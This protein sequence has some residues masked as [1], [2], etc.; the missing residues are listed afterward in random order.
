MSKPLSLLSL[1]NF[2]LHLNFSLLTHYLA[3]ISTTF[4]STILNQ[5]KYKIVHFNFT[6]DFSYGSTVGI[7]VGL[8]YGS[9]IIRQFDVNNSLKACFPFAPLSLVFEVCIG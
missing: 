7:L 3:I 4:I 1:E 9:D 2:F 6:L 5:C 8:F